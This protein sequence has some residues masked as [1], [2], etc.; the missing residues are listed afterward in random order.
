MTSKNKLKDDLYGLILTGG[1]SSRMGEDK[2]FL[3]YHGIPQVEYLYGL[4]SQ[5]LPRVYLSV[6]KPSHSYSF[7]NHL[8]EDAYEQESPINGIVSALESCPKKSFLVLAVD[9]PLIT[10][11]ALQL[12]LKM[13]NSQATATAFSSRAT[14]LP[15]PLIAIWE[16]HSIREL[17]NYFING[18]KCPRNFLIDSN[19]T[20]I[21]PNQ[22][23]DIFNANYPDEFL[24][25]KSKLHQVNE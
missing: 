19:C 14:N 4:L 11:S 25:A 1:K 15:E 21:F 8:I 2:A 22:E 24:S 10:K 18:G 17:K 9:L 12:L 20:Q 16:H 7:T 23:E 3:N 13:R 6:K 5:L